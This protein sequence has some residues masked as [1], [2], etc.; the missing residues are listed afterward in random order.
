MDRW[1]VET[2]MKIVNLKKKSEMTFQLFQSVLDAPIAIYLRNQLLTQTL[3]LFFERLSRITHS[4]LQWKSLIKTTPSIRISVSKLR[5]ALV[6]RLFTHAYH[7]EF[8]VSISSACNLVSQ[9]VYTGLRFLVGGEYEEQ[10]LQH[11]LHS[12]RVGPVYWRQS[13]P[14]WTIAGVTSAWVYDQECDF[15]R[16][17]FYAVSLLH[18][19]LICTEKQ[20]LVLRA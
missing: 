9:P 14:W 8:S 16:S 11:L 17:L 13:W 19:V 4:S 1:N 6:P 7:F 18:V 12:H 10:W 3:I 20:H 15:F 2:I 5:T